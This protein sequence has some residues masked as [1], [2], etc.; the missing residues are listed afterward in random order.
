M[1]LY[2]KEARCVEYIP[3]LYYKFYSIKYFLTKKWVN[4]S[5][6]KLNIRQ[7][8]VVPFIYLNNEQIIILI[9]LNNVRLNKVKEYYF[10][11]I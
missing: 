1:V 2:I 8:G 6:F 9:S 10:H 3:N 7:K 11:N 4:L 5:I